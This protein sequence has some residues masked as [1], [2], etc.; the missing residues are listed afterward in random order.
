[1]VLTRRGKKVWSFLSLHYK[2]ED[3][4]GYNNC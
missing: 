1:M 4:A 3:Y 2:E